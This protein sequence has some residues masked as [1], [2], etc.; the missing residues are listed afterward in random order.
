MGKQLLNRRLYLYLKLGFF[1]VLMCHNV[2]T[3]GVP[4]TKQSDHDGKTV[5][6]PNTTTG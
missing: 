5:T 6:D 4:I 3:A 2:S 1:F